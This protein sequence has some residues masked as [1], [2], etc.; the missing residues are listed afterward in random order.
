MSFPIPVDISL[1]MDLDR[2]LGR[3]RMKRMAEAYLAAIALP[4]VHS[5]ALSPLSSASPSLNPIR[6]HE[7]S[8]L[9]YT[10]EARGFDTPPARP[11]LAPPGAP[12]RPRRPSSVAFELDSPLPSLVIPPPP[13]PPALPAE[14]ECAR[15]SRIAQAGFGLRRS[16]TPPEGNGCRRCTRE[17]AK[18]N[19]LAELWDF[20]MEAERNPCQETIE[21]GTTALAI[22]HELYPEYDNMDLANHDLGLIDAGLTELARQNGM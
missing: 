3:A 1:L 18:K 10:M 2:E 8:R 5:P 12:A 19:G 16:S 11:S 14:E 9:G 20:L 15:H 21:R 22:F 7:S 4:P 13:P 6:P 17:K